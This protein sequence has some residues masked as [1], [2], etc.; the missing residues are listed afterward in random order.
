MRS[1][2]PAT[3]PARTIEEYSG[4]KV[5][6]GCLAIASDSGRA[7]GDVLDQLLLDALEGTGARLALED[8]QRLDDRDCPPPRGSPAE[9]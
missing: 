5:R 8:R 2:T 3:S 9:S 6:S 7:G 1:S 4:L